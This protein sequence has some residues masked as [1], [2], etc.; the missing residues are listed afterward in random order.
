MSPT[1]RNPGDVLIQL[2]FPRSNVDP[3]PVVD[4]SVTD[5][6]SGVQ[7]VG[8]RLTAD[9]F[10]SLMSC[11]A[12]RVSGA[13]IPSPEHVHRIG[14]ALEVDSKSLGH[15]ASH[16]DV[17][18][19]RADYLNNGWDTAEARRTNAGPQVIARRWVEAS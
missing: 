17:E 7:L 13:R 2:S 14:R 19:V 18:A 11:T 9:E 8:V 10:A 4:L 5:G 12:T 15:G 16:Q 1:D 6:M 3:G